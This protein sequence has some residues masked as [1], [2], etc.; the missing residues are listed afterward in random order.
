MKQHL[1][2]TMLGFSIICGQLAFAT[3]AEDTTITIDSQTPGITPF[4]AQLTLTASDTSVLK[5]IQFTVASKFGSAIR[6]LSGT[7]SMQYLTDRGYLVPPNNQIF[8]P[9]YGLYN[10]F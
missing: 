4:I 10:N 9:V 8:L 7:Y 5:T 6:P 3:Q 1:L 2:A